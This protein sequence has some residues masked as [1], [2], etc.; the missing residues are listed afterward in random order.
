MPNISDEKIMQSTAC[1][2]CSINCGLKIQVKNGGFTRIQGDK[3]HPHSEG[4]ICQKAMGLNHYQNHARRLT[5]PMRKKPDGG[6]EAI[7]WETAI[8]E[9]AQKLT[10]IRDTFG[11]SAIAYYGGGGQTNHLGGAYAQPFRKALKTPYVYSALAQEKTGSFWVNGK[12]FGQQNCHTTEGFEA[13]DYVLIIGSNPWQSHG[14]PQA[15]KV[16]KQIAKNPKRQMV[17]ID[18]RRTETAKM[19]DI[20]LQVKPG[21]DAFLLSAFLAVIIQ[22]E[23]EDTAF[24]EEHT[25]GFDELRAVFREIPVSEYAKKAGLAP[26]LVRK[27]ARGFATA[28]SASV[29]HD[30]GI[31]QTLHSTLNTYLEKL[32]FLI[33]GHF[34]RPGCNPA[35]TVC[36]YLDTFER[37]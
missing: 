37:T 23:R 18:P 31:E 1:I 24:L 5:H 36:S 10:K 30:L 7:T 25:L 21:M 26:E 16:L 4:Y 22:E 9:V 35:H 6:F 33:T 11:G 28:H 12:L 8:H 19:A 29:R 2:L 20:H 27:V 32:L 13:A 15:R 17:V 14:I 34:A 3:Q